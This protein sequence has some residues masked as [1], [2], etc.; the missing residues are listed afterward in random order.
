MLIVFS[1]MKTLQIFV[2]IVLAAVALGGWFYPVQQIIQVASASP[3]GTTFASSKVAQESVTTA[4]DTVFAMIN[5]DS[6][7]RTITSADVFLANGA[8]TSSVYTI[9]CATSSVATGL[10]GNTNYIFNSSFPV[11][12]GTTT[13]GNNFYV[14]TSSPGIIATTTSVTGSPAANYI[15]NFARDWAS[16]S[17]LVCKLA[18][19][20]G[21]DL[22]T[23][24]ANMTGY[25]AFP[26]RG[27]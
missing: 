5:S 22:N 12:Y 23:F 25:I 18:T 1:N 21:S 2:V 11:T 8:A 4:T 9:Q 20:Q 3:A 24:D 26:Y 7:D 14:A 15:D 27:Q 13:V 17:Y 16:G 6:N 10:N 19:S